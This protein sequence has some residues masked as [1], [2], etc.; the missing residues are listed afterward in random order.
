ME[1]HTAIFK[2][3]IREIKWDYYISDHRTHRFGWGEHAKHVMEEISRRRNF[4]RI[5]YFLKTETFW[6]GEVPRP[7]FEIG[8]EVWV[9]ELNILVEITKKYRTTNGEMIY[10]TS[11]I[12]KDVISENIEDS[13]LKAI[14]RWFVYKYP[15]L[16][17]FD[18]LKYE[19]EAIEPEPEPE[20]EELKPY[21]L[22]IEEKPKEK[23]WFGWL[24]FFKND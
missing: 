6:S 8:E 2:G 23:T 10:E 22:C 15:E 16:E 14:E 24:K 5:A 20:I 18:E 7:T 12:I 1:K 19:F 4:R 3:V 21:D 13:R 17:R 9:S 11:H